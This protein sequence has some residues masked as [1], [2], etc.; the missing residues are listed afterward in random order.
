[1]RA[2]PFETS[3]TA[4]SA[5]RIAAAAAVA[6][7]LAAFVLVT[8]VLSAEYGKDSTGTGKALGLVDLHQAKADERTSLPPA[9]EGTPQPRS[10]KVDSSEPHE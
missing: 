4:A 7:V 3:A 6:I 10:C 8:A 9:A 2:S 5:R 1:M